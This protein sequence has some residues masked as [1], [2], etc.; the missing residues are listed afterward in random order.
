MALAEW[1][2]L[3]LMVTLMLPVYYSTFDLQFR[4]GQ[5]KERKQD[6]E[7]HRVK[8]QTIRGSIEE[9]R[10]EMATEEEVRKVKEAVYILHS[11][12]DEMQRLVEEGDFLRGGD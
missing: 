5:M 9:I 12:H 7:E 3:G 2:V 4:T 6:V 11:D 10:N 1:Q 8:I